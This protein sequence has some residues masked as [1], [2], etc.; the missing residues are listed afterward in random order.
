MKFERRCRSKSAV[1]TLSKSFQNNPV[2]ALPSAT[3]KHRR[4]IIRDDASDS[5]AIRT[6]I[7]THSPRARLDNAETTSRTRISSNLQILLSDSSSRDAGGCGPGSLVLDIMYVLLRFPLTLTA[8]FFLFPA[9]FKFGGT[10]TRECPS[11]RASVSSRTDTPEVPPGIA[12]LALRHACAADSGVDSKLCPTPR[13]RLSSPTSGFARGCMR[14]PTPFCATV[15]GHAASRPIFCYPPV[16]CMRA[17]IGARAGL[18]TVWCPRREFAHHGHSGAPPGALCLERAH[19]RALDLASLPPL[20][21]DGIIPAAPLESHP[22]PPMSCGCV[23]VL[24]IASIA[25]RQT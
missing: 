1:Y 16:P 24:R 3:C 8:P 4:R 2:V 13:A 7:H 12:I 23:G 14:S 22:R 18:T 21:L 9:V 15:D 11:P 17:F 5:A 6:T 10:P 25:P 19:Q 20:L